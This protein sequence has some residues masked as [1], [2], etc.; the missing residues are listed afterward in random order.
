MTI[1]LFFTLGYMGPASFCLAQFTPMAKI[2]TMA[3]SIYIDN[4]DNTYLLTPQEELLKYDQNGKLKWRYSNN[5]YGKAHHIDTAD[6]LRTV[7]FY[8]DFQQVIVLNNNLNEITSYSFAHNTNMQVTALA[9]SNNNGFWAYD[10]TSNTLLKLSSNFTEDMRSASLYQL[11]DEMVI[12][13]KMQA[14]DQYVY[15]QRQN[16]EILQFDRF[17]AY[18]KLLPIDSLGDFNITK[19]QIAFVKNN[20]L[21]SYNP[22]TGSDTT[23]LLPL[24][25]PIKQVA[26]GNKLIAVLT[27]KA[28][29]LLA[30]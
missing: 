6:P 2:D 4:L 5:R 17:G 30:R 1:F 20:I 14:T 10:Q 24:K 9:S 29:F 16:N 11:F 21:H 3:K 27:E 18:I 13:K 8:N 26:I 15:L 12:A 7:V 28:V 25:Q 23:T 22:V 19:N